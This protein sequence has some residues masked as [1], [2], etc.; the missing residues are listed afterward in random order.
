MKRK[1]Q[2][3]DRR[4]PPRNNRDEQPTTRPVPVRHAAAPR[5]AVRDAQVATRDITIRDLAVRAE[6]WNPEDRSFQAVMTTE[7]PVRVMD[8]RTWEEID[9]VLVAD[10]GEFPER[11]PLLDSHQRW[12]SVDVVGSARGF[13]REGQQWVGRGYFAA[14]DP[15]VDRIASRVRDGHITDVSIGYEV[16]SWVDIPTG[17]T[18]TVNGRSYTA[19]DRT[20]RITTRWRGRELSVTPIGADELAKIRQQHAAARPQRN[21]RSRAMNK[22]LREYLRSLGLADGASDEEASAMHA[23]LRGLQRTIAGILDYDEADQQARTS[24]DLAIRSLGYDPADPTKQLAPAPTP[25]AEPQRTE[26]AAPAAATP[27]AAPVDAEAIRREAASDERQRQTQLRELAQGLVP[28]EMLTRAIDEGWTIERSSPLFLQA[29]RDSRGQPLAGDA[30]TGAPAG[31]TRN[32]QTNFERDALVAA[33]MLRGS[34]GG[35][36]SRQSGISDPVQ[37][38]FVCNPST[39]DMRF[40]DASRDD[41]WCRAVERGYELRALPMVEVGRRVLE[42]HGVRVEPVAEHVIRAFMETRAAAA[43]QAYV[44]IYTQT[45]GALL[46]ES[47]LG[48]RDSTAPWTIERDNPNFL[49]N[50][51]HRVTKGRALTKHA[52]GGEAED[53]DAGAD[54][55]EYT[56]VFRYSGKTAI[57]EVDLINDTMFNALRTHTPEEMGES[58]RR[59]RPDLVYAILLANGNLQDG[60]ALFNATYGNLLYSAAISLANIQRGTTAIET[61]QENGVN[62]DLEA[63]F[64]IVPKAIRYTAREIVRATTVVIAGDTDTTRAN[65]NALTEDA[66]QVIPDSRLDNGVTD[67]DSGTAH[68]GDTGDYYVAATANRHTI[69]VTRLRGGARVPV[70]R[71]GMF[72]EPGKWGIW[73]DVKEDLGAKALGRAGLCKLTTDAEP[74]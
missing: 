57:D 17:Q 7:T 62:L 20:L 44:G 6:S 10:G 43:T 53:Y 22:R 24:A 9:E 37:R 40:V 67:P 50:E 33:M 34:T 48:T 72:N 68:S 28:D 21:P 66:L 58:A 47:Y 5:L 54:T 41:G 16:L 56:K 61:R 59:L 18:Q 13:R 8:R 71:A 52:K 11:M 39:G 45:F 23:G 64:L 32:S 31:H 42:Q 38:R 36:G 49:Q 25:P 1:P 14:D 4:Q 46:L 30:P 55:T 15:E 70:M 12:Q 19:A 69:E 27:P 73:F 51:R 29:I 60:S 3:T 2:T 35:A 26:P 65:Y 63:K 74:G